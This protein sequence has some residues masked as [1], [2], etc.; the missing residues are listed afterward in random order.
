[1]IKLLAVKSK[2]IAV[3][4]LFLQKQKSKNEGQQR[5]LQWER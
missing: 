5:M 2:L 3:D 4:K 1:M